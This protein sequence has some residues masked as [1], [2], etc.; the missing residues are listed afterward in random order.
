MADLER[1]VKSLLNETEG[2]EDA[3]NYIEDIA[4]DL[5][6]DAEVVTELKRQCGRG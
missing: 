4:S 2:Y 5:G 6:V 3:L 1:E